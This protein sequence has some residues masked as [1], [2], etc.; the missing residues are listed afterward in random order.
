MALYI[1][2]AMASKPR[3][4]VIPNPKLKLLEQVS[5]VMRFRPMK[6]GA[7]FPALPGP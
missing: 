6:R 1:E 3:E 7:R 2:K 4:S 5:E